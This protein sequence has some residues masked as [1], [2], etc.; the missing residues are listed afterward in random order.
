M[1]LSRARRGRFFLLLVATTLVN[2]GA[3]LSPPRTPPAANGSSEPVVPAPAVAS[4]SPAVPA[5][6]PAVAPKRAP[7]PMTELDAWAAV[8]LMGRGV[9]I[10]NT[11]ENTT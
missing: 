7:E 4:G 1:L 5:A 2:L 8:P 3:C 11:L 10:G 9:N 6:D